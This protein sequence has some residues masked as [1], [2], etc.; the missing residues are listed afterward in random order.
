[1]SVMQEISKSFDQFVQHILTEKLSERDI[2][3][4]NEWSEP[5]TRQTQYSTS[6]PGSLSCPSPAPLGRV[7]ENPGNE[8]DAAAAQCACRGGVFIFFIFKKAILRLLP[9]TKWVNVM[10]DLAYNHSF[11]DFVYKIK[12]EIGSNIH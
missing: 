10:Q 4:V 8:V 3:T 6:F 11:I 2:A 9:F 5:Q 7:G 1:M 12:I